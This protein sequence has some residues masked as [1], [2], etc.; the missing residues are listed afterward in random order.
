MPYFT[1]FLIK[2]NLIMYHVLYVM[3]YPQNWLLVMASLKYRAVTNDYFDDSL[4]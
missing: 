4:I 2:R 3:H 1:G